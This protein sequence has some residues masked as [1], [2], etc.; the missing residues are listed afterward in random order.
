MNAKPALLYLETENQDHDP[1]ASAAMLGHD[2]SESPPIAPALGS[3]V[4]PSSRDRHD[5]HT[6]ELQRARNLKPTSTNDKSTKGAR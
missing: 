5:L 4:N 1:L 2:A 3:V 6:L